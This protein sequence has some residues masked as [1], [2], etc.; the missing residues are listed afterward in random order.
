MGKV[1]LYFY[2]LLSLS[3]VDYSSK[4]GTQER[5]FLQTEKCRNDGANIYIRCADG[6]QKVI[7]LGFGE[8]SIVKDKKIPAAK[9]FCNDDLGELS[10]NIRNARVYHRGIHAQNHFQISNQISVY[11]DCIE[12]KQLETLRAFEEFKLESIPITEPAPS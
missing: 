6:S 3:C 2:I 7:A 4:L 10:I 8:F 12:T 5:I 1:V 11:S 9:E